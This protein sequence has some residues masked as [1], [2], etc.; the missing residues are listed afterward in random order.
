MKEGAIE[1]VDGTTL[2]GP[3]GTYDCVV[4]LCWQREKTVNMLFFLS[5]CFTTMNVRSETLCNTTTA[6]SFHGQ[7]L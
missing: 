6:I 3:D 2:K 1:E 4:E 5:I 7:S